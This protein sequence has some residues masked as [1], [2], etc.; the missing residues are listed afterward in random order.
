MKRVPSCGLALSS[1]PVPWLF[2][3]VCSTEF[4]TGFW[5]SRSGRAIPAVPFHPCLLLLTDGFPKT[6]LGMLKELLGGAAGARCPQVHYAPRWA[7]SGARQM[8]CRPTWLWLWAVLLTDRGQPGRPPPYVK[9]DCRDHYMAL[10][11]EWA[12]QQG[13]SHWTPKGRSLHWQLSTHDSLTKR[14][15]WA[16]PASVLIPGFRHGMPCTLRSVW[17][18]FHVQLSPRTH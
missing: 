1:V 17:K 5:L 10:D 4:K 13:G 6:Q 3:E 9:R 12:A 14:G 15:L 16:A 11:L 2:F 18:F 8:G 7:S